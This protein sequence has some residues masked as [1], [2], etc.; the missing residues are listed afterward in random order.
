MTEFD[1]G[2]EICRRAYVEVDLDAIREN[3]EKLSGN[4]NEGTRLMAV[5]KADG[6][7]HGSV[8]VAR[9]LEPYDFCFGFAVATSEEAL[10]LRREGITKPVLILGY[11]FPDAFEKL[12]QEEVRLTVFRRDSIEP[13]TAAAKSAGK[14]VRVHVKVDTGMSRIGI[15]PDDSGLGLIRELGRAEGIE[16]EG[17]FTHFARADESCKEDTNRQFQLFQSFTERVERELGRKIPIKHCANSAAI[18]DLPGMGLSAAR[19]GIALYGVYPSAQVN[20]GSVQLKPALSLFSTITCVKTITRGTSVSY[21][22]TFTADRDMRVAT[23]PVGYGDGY[24]RSLSGKGKVLIRGCPAPILGRVCMD[25]FMVDVSHIPGAAEGE[26]VVLIGEDGEERLDVE[27][28]GELSG[29]FPYEFLCDL[30]MRL[31]RV[32][33]QGGRVTALQEYFSS[34]LPV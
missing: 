7:G 2:L 22:G 32:Y 1:S 12:S 6:Y 18:L 8:P 26:K 23:I 33:V 11:T 19:A 31:P 34:V 10:I 30:G 25:Q 9:C 17:I 27:M 13:L 3:A 4:L 21:G 14:P 28:L 20:R 5:V 29:R 24:P 16:I 15:M